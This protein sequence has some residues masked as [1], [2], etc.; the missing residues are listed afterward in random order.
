MDKEKKYD[1]SL[2]GDIR[3]KLIAILLAV[4][5]FS[6]FVQ[7]FLN[8]LHSTLGIDFKVGYYFFLFL[9]FIMPVILVSV[10]VRQNL[11]FINSWTRSGFSGYR[12][13]YYF[14]G[15]SLLVLGAFWSP[16][17]GYVFIGLSVLLILLI[18]GL[19]FS[20]IIKDKKIDKQEREYLLFVSIALLIAGIYFWNSYNNTRKSQETNK[21]NSCDVLDFYDFNY[22]V[23]ENLLSLSGRIN[24]YAE[25]AGAGTWSLDFANA[26]HSSNYLRN[27]S[28]L[29]NINSQDPLIHEIF[30]SARV[31]L[32]DGYQMLDSCEFHADSLKKSLLEVDNC[33]KIYERKL[34]VRTALLKTSDSRAADSIK[35]QIDRYRYAVQLISV[36]TEA[37]VRKSDS[38]LRTRWLQQT[39]YLQYIGLLWFFTHVI[40]L[41]TALY[42]FRVKERLLENEV[43]KSKQIYRPRA[44]VMKSV[45]EGGGV[46]ERNRD[47]SQIYLIQEAGNNAKNLLLLFLLLMA[48]YF[49]HF[50]EENISLDRPLLNFDLQEIVSGRSGSDFSNSGKRFS[51]TSILRFT[52]I[53]SIKVIADTLKIDSQVF[54]QQRILNRLRDLGRGAIDDPGDREQY[55]KQFDSLPV[56]R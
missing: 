45:Y 53:D 29:R 34:S 9:Y 4:V 39:N 5:C 31:F 56:K 7:T 1:L 27:D 46:K 51:D 41:F 15:L 30:S 49:K 54:D 3:S 8:Q 55:L 21:H 12:S 50:T 10:F 32:R 19:A 36:S 28:T 6:T 47:T 33:L 26:G 35:Q 24:N 25:I 42:F 23:K 52:N 17:I 44:E 48:P 2:L 43:P 11:Q 37:F 16:G 22:D 14:A 40:F 13:L 20:E 18:I 38:E